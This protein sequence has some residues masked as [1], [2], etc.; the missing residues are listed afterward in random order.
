MTGENRFLNVVLAPVR[1]ARATHRF[2]LLVAAA[3][4]AGFFA[5]LALLNATGSFG[6][7]LGRS[8]PAF[9]FVDFLGLAFIAFAAPYGWLEWRETRRV[10]EIEERMPDFLS[11]LASLH[12]AGL[13]LMEAI[14]VAST[15]N[16]GALTPDVRHAAAQIQWGVPVLEAL[17]LLR[18]RLGTPMVNRTLTVVIEAGHAGGNVK[19]VLMIAAGIAR[20]LAI[21]RRQ[22]KQEMTL[23]LLIVY[24]ASAVFLFVVLALQGVFIP[25][26]VEAVRGVGAGGAVLGLGG[27][28]SAEAFR[29]LYVTTAVVSSIGN[30]FVAGMMSDGR[31]EAG[32]KHAAIMVAF[33]LLAF[34]MFG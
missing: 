18:D 4:F 21:M 19:E 11:D 7:F 28:P 29:G 6:S 10:S 1:N 22:R 17:A 12:K 8:L 34:L 14:R 20:Q 33:A 2:L 30:G 23:Y 15:G 27:I 9:A 24:V 25:R 16:Y 32:V 31:Y 26:M 5:F 13:T 3:C